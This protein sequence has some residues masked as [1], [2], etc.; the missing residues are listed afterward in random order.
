MANY[1][2]MNPGKYHLGTPFSFPPK[3][4]RQY[5]SDNRILD[6]KWK[7]AVLIGRRVYLGNVKITNKDNTEKVLS[8]SVFKSKSNQ[9]DTFTTDRRLDV[10]IGDGEEVIK[11]IGYADRLLEFKQNTLFIINVTKDSEYLESTHKYK[12]V[13]HP[14]A[15]CE[16]DYGIAWCNSHGVYF[17]DGQ[18]VSEL[19][20][21]EGIRTLSHTTWDGFYI[22]KQ[23][24]ISYIP[25]TKQLLFIR[26]NNAATSGTPPDNIGNVMIYNMTLGSW[27]K[28]TG[29]LGE[30]SKSNIVSIWDGRPVYADAT[31]GS[32]LTMY[33]WEPDTLGAISN[34]KVQTK[35]INFG[36]QSKKKVSKVRISYKGSGTNV[37]IL[38]KYAINGGPFDFLFNNSA[39]DTITGVTQTSTDLTKRYLAG[40]TNWTEID[41]YTDSNANNIRS[42]AIQLTGSTGSNTIVS[43]N[44]EINDITTIFR[45]KSVK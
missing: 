19:L 40:S 16:T 2:L 7:T 29:R 34:Y 4:N 14:T 25:S 21:R 30:N 11:L 13:S 3:Q 10:A 23:T 45:T 8:D 27:T 36:T 9:F 6:I 35:E 31:S 5:R 44:F 41:L 12:G 37:N 22:D 42:F 39:G 28:G 32:V 1:A 17:Y 15:V 33:P 20:L 26:G 18:Q 38:P 24:M 43:S